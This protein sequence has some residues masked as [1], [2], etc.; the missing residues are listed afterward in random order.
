MLTNLKELNFSCFCREGHSKIVEEIKEDLK[1]KKPSV[2]VASVGGGGLLMGLVKGLEAVGKL[3]FS[4]EKRC[5]FGPR[6]AN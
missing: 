5:I 1:G 3:V 2:I 4:S 6:C